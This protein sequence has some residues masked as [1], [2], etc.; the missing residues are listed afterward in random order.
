MQAYGG[1]GSRSCLHIDGTKALFNNPVYVQ[2]ARLTG[3]KNI[4]EIERLGPYEIYAKAWGL[5][6]KTAIPVTED[7]AYVGIRAHHFKAECNGVYEANA[8]LAVLEAADESPFEFHYFMRISR[9]R[10]KKLSGGR[11]RSFL[12]TEAS[13][14]K[15][16]VYLS[17]KPEDLM[18]LKK[19]FV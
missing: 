4:S 2:A 5:T 15:L 19:T 1:D 14:G 17:V 12:R 3:C 18:L 13:E 10:K 16:Q 8:F 6:F 11:Y 9:R 7:I